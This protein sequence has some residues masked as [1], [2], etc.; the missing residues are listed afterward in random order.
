MRQQERVFD[1]WLSCVCFVDQG[2]GSNGGSG[3]R[4]RWRLD[5]ADDDDDDD[6]QQAETSMALQQSAA[7]KSG[8]RR[9][10]ERRRWC[11]CWW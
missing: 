7:T 10:V 9:R 4:H 2:S 3:G 5:G 1:A 8:M 6:V 11:Y